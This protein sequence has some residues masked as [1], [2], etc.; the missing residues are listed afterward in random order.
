LSI[1]TQDP[2]AVEA[3][4]K[5]EEIAQ[6]MNFK[7]VGVVVN[8]VRKPSLF[9]KPKLYTRGQIQSRLRTPIIL[10][11]PEDFAVTEAATLRRPMVFH[12]PKSAVAK[13]IRELAHKLGA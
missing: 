4:V 10:G 6:S 1:T 2:A 7:L 8:R 5:L 9:K 13:S 3:A 12:R 11:I